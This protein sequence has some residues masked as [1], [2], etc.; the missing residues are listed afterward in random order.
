MWNPSQPITVKNESEAT[1]QRQVWIWCHPCS[2]DQI[3]QEFSKCLNL[4]ETKVEK[5]SFVLNKSDT[6]LCNKEKTN[7]PDS[8]KTPFICD[9]YKTDVVC[10][11]ADSGVSMRSLTGSLLRFNLTGPQSTAVLVDTLQQAN[12]VPVSFSGNNEAW[13]KGF[14][15][16]PK[17]SIGYVTQREFME[18]IGSCQSP[19][20]L[21]PRCVVGLTT[22]DPRLTRPSQRT[23][24]VTE[25]SGRYG[26]HQKLFGLRISERLFIPFL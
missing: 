23:K 3:W 8:A 19:S 25:E 15:G 14:Y 21:P 12:I 26:G 20:E 6:Q 18:S 10:S 7:L 5:N 13:W 22:R 24:V 17:Y 2:F 9:K 11:G 1:N 16:N 4:T